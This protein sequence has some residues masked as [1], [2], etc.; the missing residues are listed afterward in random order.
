MHA[1]PHCADVHVRKRVGRPGPSIALPS[2]AKQGE[3]S[4]IV[5]TLKP[6]AG[7]VT[8][9]GD[10]HFVVT[11]HGVADLY[12]KPISQRA[13]SLIAVA[14]PQFRDQLTREAKQLGLL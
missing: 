13:A 8:S 10:V 2:T 4:R 11:E 9:R 1:R 3:L 7:V 5:S 6:G 12:A 14:D